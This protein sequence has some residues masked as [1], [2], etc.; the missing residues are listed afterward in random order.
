LVAKPT[1]SNPTDTI[2]IPSQIP[3]SVFLVLLPDKGGIDFQDKLGNYDWN[4]EF[5]LWQGPP[6]AL[7]LV[8]VDSMGIQKKKFVNVSK[9]S[10]PN[11]SDVGPISPDS[12]KLILHGFLFTDSRA[13]GTI[14]GEDREGRP[15]KLELLP[16]DTGFCP[17]IFEYMEKLPNAVEDLS[18]KPKGVLKKNF[19]KNEGT[20]F[21]IRGRQVM[22]F[23]SY[24]DFLLKKHSLPTGVYILRF[25]SI[26]PKIIKISVHK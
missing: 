25:G 3:D 21:N 24:N 9:D 19:L 12:S 18:T 23:N 10:I 8:L 4:S 13:N 1:R 16:C 6:G 14:V 22:S 2:L 17:L 5:I 20:L 26:P 11:F 15:F 7:I